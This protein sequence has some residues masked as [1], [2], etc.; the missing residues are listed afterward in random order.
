MQRLSTQAIGQ[1]KTLH[2]RTLVELIDFEIN[3]NRTDL[4]I[5]RQT[6]NISGHFT[7]LE[8]DLARD[9]FAALEVR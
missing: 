9:M 1:R 5:N 8:I 4:E 6:R 3:L 2:F 7:T